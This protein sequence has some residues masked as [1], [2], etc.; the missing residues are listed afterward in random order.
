MSQKIIIAIFITLFGLPLLV[1]AQAQGGTLKPGIEQ[2]AGTV[3]P[4]SSGVT[5]NVNLENPFTPKSFDQLIS[6]LLDILIKVGSVLALVFIIY[7]GFLFVTAGGSEDQITK[8]KATFLWTI[9]GVAIVLGAKAI[10][11][12][13]TGTVTNVIGR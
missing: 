12:L 7:S 5:E 4:G 2:Q 1:S 8:A 10:Q 9:I 3:K 6:M 11:V 13:I